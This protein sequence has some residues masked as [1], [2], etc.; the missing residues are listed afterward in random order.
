MSRLITSSYLVL[1]VCLF[2]S[3]SFAQMTKTTIDEITGNPG[4]YSDNA[5]EVE[6]F[7]KQY[8]PPTSTSTSYY[9]LM[10]DYGAI[11]KVNTSESAPEIG[12]KYHVSGI[13]Y[14]DPVSREPFVSEKSKYVLN[15]E[16]NVI[17]DSNGNSTLIVVV[18]LL[19]ILLIGILV[20]L[21]L[22]AKKSKLNSNEK[23]E[24][25]SPA[26]LEAP[27]MDF[28]TIRLTPS[29]P[30]TM[31]FIRG[32]LILISGDDKGKAFKIAGYPAAEGS[33]VTIGREAVSGERSY[34]H[35]QIDNKFQTVS[36]R[37]A[38]IISVGDQLFVRNLS[39][40]NPTQVDGIEL[41][42]GEKK[43]LRPNST[44]KTGELE[45]KYKV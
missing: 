1:T 16:K 14:I 10:S 42:S 30:K 29:A 8:I 11:I 25:L 21:Q 36:R 27:Q 23:N 18:L 7:V 4:K 5:V 43:E 2:F 12:K 6:G 26:G 38:E 41:K 39:D 34:A 37:Q 22:K 15:S 3:L 20:Y 44:I 28:K 19:I 17:V 32:E 31:K 45:F 35:I 33:I 40:T 24:P 9:L 13:V